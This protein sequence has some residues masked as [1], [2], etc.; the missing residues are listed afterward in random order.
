MK[1]VAIIPV[2][3]KSDRVT[4]KNFRDF[5][6][7]DS[8][9]SIK[10]KQLVR[11]DIFESIYISSDS[12]LAKKIA[13]NYGVNFIPREKSFCNNVTPWSDVIYNVVSSIPEKDNVHLAWCHTTSP[14]F[15]KFTE[16]VEV[17]KKIIKNKKY[18]GLI[19]VSECKEF[20]I[21]S[22][23]QPVNYQWGPWHKYSQFLQD[24]FFITG[25]FF[26]TTKAN[27]LSNRYV[28][29]TNPYLHTTSKL[30]AIDIDDDYDF[31]LA[32]LIAADININND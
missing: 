17:Y 7:K 32:K 19:T 1:F 4:S 8:L 22:N 29:S 16:A 2:K 14:F 28:I 15:Y 20:I 31:N 18:D 11:S 25:A 6:K 23:L 26:L 9:L 21:N 3:E 13:D 24:Y 10:I 27:M 30:E 12:S 5:Y